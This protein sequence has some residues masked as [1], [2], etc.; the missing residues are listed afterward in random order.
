MSISTY[1]SEVKDS[2]LV[3]GEKCLEIKDL[4]IHFFTREGVVRA[5]DGASFSVGKGE[6]FGI[7]GESGCGK[8]VT[9]RAA[10]NMVRKPGKILS[11]EVLWRGSSGKEVSVLDLSSKSAEMRAI[12]GKEISMIFQE[13]MSALSPVYSIEYQ[14][15]EALRLYFPDLPIAEAKERAAELLGLV[16]I[17]NPR[18]QL[19]GYSFQLSGGMCQRVMIAMALSGEP[20]LLI[21]DEPTTA[22]DVTVQAQILELLSDLQ[23]KLGMAIVFISHN[24]GVIASMVSRMVVMYLGQVVEEGTSEDIFN[25]PSHPYTRALLGSMPVPGKDRK[26]PMNA[27]PGRVPDGSAVITGCNFRTRCPYAIAGTCDTEEPE[28]IEVSPGHRVRCVLYRAE[29]TERRVASL[30]K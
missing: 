19:K 11:G 2:D 1:E 9:V 28:L 22:L 26:Q 7:V 23:E 20:D 4:K 13:P 18:R 27:I 10:M 16:G 17:P 12:R 6:S 29:N 14:M 25:N 3:T 21:A 8:S 30:G 24:L 15:V 5:V